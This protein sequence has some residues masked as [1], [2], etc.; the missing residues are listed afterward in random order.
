M[1][2]IA[3]GA[4]GAPAQSLRSNPRRVLVIAPALVVAA[5]ASIGAGAI[6]AAAIGVHS[7]H[8]QAVL[9]FTLVAT[10]QIGWGVL[11]IIVRTRWFV[12]LGALANAAFV[13]GWILA[14]TSGI[15][16]I[17]GMETAEGAQ[18]A[19]TLAAG[20]AGV[21]VI[22]ALAALVTG[23][24]P[25]PIGHIVIGALALATAFATVPGM[26]AAGSHSHA[27]GHGDTAAGHGHGG[28][29]AGSADGAG[30]GHDHGSSVPPVAYDPTKPIDLGGVDGV[31]PEQQA[32]AEN[33][34]AITLLRL[35]R[36]ADP[37]VA[38]S[39]GF[40]SIGDGATGDEHYINIDYFD[41]GRILDPD[42][43]ESLVYQPQ[44]DGSK[45]LVAAMFMLAPDQT[46]D[47][48][49]DIGGKLTQWHIHNN[50]CFTA[51]GR[52]AGISTEPGKC[53]PGLNPG[54]QAPMIHV[55][56]QPHPCGPFAALEGIAGGQIRE[57]ETKLCDAAHGHGGAT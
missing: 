51:S 19:D 50:L 45:K 46:L 16:F 32:R 34:I 14:K 47:Q 25:S 48:V 56:I 49:P 2:S 18:L 26:V 12:L 38:E 22:G 41:D 4:P 37:A 11:S 17:D 52:V 7:E 57:G 54:S 35:P 24:R 39:Q 29:G 9:A 42:Y 23:L 8:R 28:E 36:F 27:G 43:P 10:A 15:S 20:L 31:S 5:F 6:H 30:G 33:L 21:A 1:T 44:K 40:R 53:R 55:W 13:G 3:A